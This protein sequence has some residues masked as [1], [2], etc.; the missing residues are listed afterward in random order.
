MAVYVTLAF[1]YIFVPSRM[2]G[3]NFWPDLDPNL[4]KRFVGVF[5]LIIATIMI[6]GFFGH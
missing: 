5:C 4:A 2:P 6:S 1:L 3:G